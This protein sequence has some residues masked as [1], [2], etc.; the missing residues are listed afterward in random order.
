[1]YIKVEVNPGAKKEKLEKLGNDSFFITV[2]EK[3][4]RN[5]ANRKVL[6][7]L[8]TYFGLPVNKL[9][10]ISGHRSRRKII[11]VLTDDLVK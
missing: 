6:L 11:S 7:L 1:M 10:L 3:A 9:R 2:R 5:L 8:A 4:E